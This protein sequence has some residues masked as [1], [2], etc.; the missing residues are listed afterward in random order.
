MA[1]RSEKPKVL[2]KRNDFLLKFFLLF[3][4]VFITMSCQEENYINQS[5]KLVPK[6]V[7]EDAS[8]PSITINGTKLHSQAFGPLNSTLIICIHGG[9]GDNFRYLLNCKS[10]AE[11][12]YRVVFYD[13]VGSGLS[14]RFS[15]NWYAEKKENTIELVFY[16]ELKNVIDFY[17]TNPN[18]K[19]VLLTHSWGSILATGFAGK[20]PNE[21]NGMILAEP[22]GLKWND[23]KAYVESSL[24][25]KL[26]SEAFNDAAYLDQF[27]TAKENDHNVL[28]YK[29][30]LLRSSSTITGEDSPKLG[31]NVSYYPSQRQGA[32]ISKAMFEFG[33]KYNPDFTIGLNNFNQKVLFLYSSNNKAYSTN[34]AQKI[35]AVFINKELYQVNGVGHSG[36]FDQINI[37]NSITEPKILSYLSNL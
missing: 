18:Q 22:G 10:L 15:N 2:F 29:L 32:V 25:N 8:I 26:W 4:L 11:K 12:G 37:W 24:S 17:K 6:T 19:V 33:K 3:F 36:M 7:T 27:I 28:D 9:P 35:S 13:Q 5:G 16:K 30:S 21:I 34:W 31:A 14:Q 1:S 20:Y 23:I